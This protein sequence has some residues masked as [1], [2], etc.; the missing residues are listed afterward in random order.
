M[1]FSPFATCH[2][3]STTGSAGRVKGTPDLFCKG[4]LVTRKSPEKGVLAK[5]H[6]MQKWE[7]AGSS[8]VGAGFAPGGTVED[9][10]TAS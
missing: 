8:T 4:R 10:E 2:L 1:G 3:V 9:L 6:D 7:E 5:L